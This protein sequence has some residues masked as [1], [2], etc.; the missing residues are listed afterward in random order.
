MRLLSLYDCFLTDIHSVNIDPNLPSAVKISR[1]ARAIKATSKSNSSLTPAIRKEITKAV[2]SATRKVCTKKGRQIC[3]KGSRGPQGSPGSQ[4]P[5]GPQGPQGKSGSQG[6]PGKSGPQ[7]P[8]GPPGPPGPQGPAGMKGDKGDPGVASS[9]TPTY[10]QPVKNQ[11][12]DLIKAPGILVQP[13]FRIAFLNESATF[14]C[15][16][17]KNVYAT[18]SWSKKD[19]SLPVGRH[20]INKGTLFIKN[21][22][23]SDNGVYVCTIHTY[24]GTAQAAVTLNIKGKRIIKNNENTF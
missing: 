18:I 20:S 13:T 24:E 23:I 17:D 22:V 6:T 12:D 3:V 1:S 8:P 19:G 11:S 14:R 4:G 21:V 10:L 15:A 2:N 16:P 5:A 7:G 9:L